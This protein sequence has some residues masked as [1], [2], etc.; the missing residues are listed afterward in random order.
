TPPQMAAQRLLGVVQLNI[1][2]DDRSAAIR[3]LQAACA[4]TDPEERQDGLILPGKGTLKA[5]VDLGDVAEKLLGTN[6]VRGSQYLHSG[7]FDWTAFCNEFKPRF[8]GRV[9]SQDLKDLLR[10]MERD[11]YVLDIRW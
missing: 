11:P 7:G 4:I 9:A 10:M 5:L 1:P 2:W 6:Q 8:H 3:A